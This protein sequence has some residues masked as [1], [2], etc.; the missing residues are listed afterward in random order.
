MKLSRFGLLLAFLTFSFAIQ[1]GEL[2]VFPLFTDHGILQQ[3]AVVPIWGKASPNTQV[4]V[5]FCGQDAVT[6][7]DADGKWTARL[8]TPKAE[9]GRMEGYD[10]TIRSADAQIVLHDVA[11]G[12]VWIGSGQSNIDTSLAQYCIG[13][14]AASTA[15]Y[16]GIRL[17]SAAC[18]NVGGG[19]SV[20]GDFSQYR[21]LVCTPETA[22]KFSAAGYFFSRELHKTLNVPVGFINM[23]VGGS[24]LSSWVL[25]EWL[26][27]D[28]RMAANME[29]F[30][31]ITFPGFIEQRKQSLAKWQAMCDE[32]KMK[33]E[34]PNPAWPPFQGPA[35]QSLKNFIGGNYITHTA[36]VMPFVFKGMLWDQGESGVGYAL[37]GD[38][39]VIFDIM[40]QKLRKGFGYDLPVVY[41]EMPKGK[42][43]GPTIHV[44]IG[45]NNFS[46]PGDAVPLADLPAEAPDAGPVFAGFSKENDPFLR[47]NALPFCA[48]ATT[49]D[50]QAALHP[51][52]KDEYGAR[53]CQTAL[54]HVYGKDVECFGP[55]ITSAKRSEGDIV[56]TFG[57]VG[58][59]LIALGGKPLQGFYTSDSNGK[60]IWAKGRIEGN[61]VI[62]SSSGISNAK[63]VSYANVNHGRVM[64]ANLFNK[65]GF[66][67]YAMTVRVDE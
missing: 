35:E 20:T 41:C 6:T 65:E 37:K 49:R 30:T 64:W 45:K 21:W 40:I 59:G 50:L 42:G 39:D 61:R 28:P 36:V 34:K 15:N 2:S 24:P 29:S 51:H 19:R 9:P 67:A 4:H 47:M 43:W 58:S 63:T 12:E 10:L 27:E 66:P 32:A 1:A 22:I 48:M 56:L 62:L 7:A 44:D 8:R 11:V 38:Y 54:H 60:S 14:K 31:T 26:S 23:A 53:F 18:G 3:D 46:M 16:P 52:S 17:Y 57:H 25:P 13:E 5:A 55:M 33:G